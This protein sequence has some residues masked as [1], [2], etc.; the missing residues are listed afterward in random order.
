MKLNF[1]PVV[2]KG[3]TGESEELWAGQ[4]HFR[5][6]EDDGA[7][8]PGSHSQAHKE[9]DGNWKQPLKT[10]QGLIMSGPNASHNDMSSSVIYFDIS[11]A[12]GTISGIVVNKP[13]RYRLRK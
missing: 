5:S 10:Y 2:R 9:R 4:P 7:N 12:F 11:N 6:W 8:P 1:R 13:V 3:R